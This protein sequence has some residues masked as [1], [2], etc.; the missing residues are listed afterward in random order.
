MQDI[1]HPVVGDKKYGAASNPLRRLGLHARVLAF[2][3]PVDG[4]QCRFESAIPRPFL[5]L[6]EGKESTRSA[7]P[8]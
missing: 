4:I 2:I 6:F 8:A 1:G 3:H 7:S 5:R